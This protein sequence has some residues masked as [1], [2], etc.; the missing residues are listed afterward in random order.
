MLT[1]GL[2]EGIRINGKIPK[3]K[4][5]ALARNASLFGEQSTEHD[6]VPCAAR[7]M[8]VVFIYGR[9]VLVHFHG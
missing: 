7:P 9:W 4:Q 2:S 3:S 8:T 6:I 5:E 1:D